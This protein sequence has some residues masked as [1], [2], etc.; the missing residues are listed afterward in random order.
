MGKAT[1]GFVVLLEE[2]VIFGCGGGGSVLAGE[3][4]GEVGGRGSGSTDEPFGYEGLDG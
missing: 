1:E 2:G 4:K 3:E